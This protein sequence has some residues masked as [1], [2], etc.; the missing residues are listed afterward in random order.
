MIKI[1]VV[2]MISRLKMMVMF[3]VMIMRMTVATIMVECICKHLKVRDHVATT[4]SACMRTNWNAELGSHQVDGQDLVN[5]TIIIII[6][7]IFI[8]ITTLMYIIKTM[9]SRT[10]QLA[11]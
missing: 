3:L 5:I 10:N 2:N 4:N 8:T 7:I 9:Q 11:W 6:I 1:L